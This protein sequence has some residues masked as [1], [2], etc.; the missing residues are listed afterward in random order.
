MS[1]E[2]LPNTSTMKKLPGER[3]VLPGSTVGGEA[4]TFYVDFVLWNWQMDRFHALNGLVDTG[5]TYPQAPAE[6]LEELGVERYDTVRFRLAD[7]SLTERSLGRAMINLEGIIRPVI[8]VF[9]PEG[10]S[11]LLGALALEVCGLAANV[12]NRRLAPADVLL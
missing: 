2:N 10:S 12:T 3:L 7:G 1:T 6:I 4:G 11:I 9:G 5:A 8:I